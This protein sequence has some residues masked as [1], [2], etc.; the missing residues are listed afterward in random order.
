MI[1]SLC[2]IVTVPYRFVSKV[3]SALITGLLVG[4]AVFCGYKV[5]L[6]GEAFDEQE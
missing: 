2:R 3:A 5:T 6:T 1:E 4:Y